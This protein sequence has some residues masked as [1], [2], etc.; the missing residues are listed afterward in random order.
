[1]RLKLYTADIF[2]SSGLLKGLECLCTQVVV[3]LQCRCSH[4]RAP[5]L[6]IGH[7]RESGKADHVINEGVKG[8]RR[9]THSSSVSVQSGEE[10]VGEGCRAGALA[11]G[12]EGDADLRE[13]PLHCRRARTSQGS[14]GAEPIPMLCNRGLP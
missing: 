3:R 14:Q 7:A 10:N 12:R 11:L 6:A 4:T 8:I 5:S 9:V 1:M 13:E 2:L